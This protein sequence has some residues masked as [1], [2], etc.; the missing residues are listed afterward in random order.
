MN[1]I[2]EDEMPTLE[3]VAHEDAKEEVK[4]NVSEEDAT[5]EVKEGD[6]G[7]EEVVKGKDNNKVEDVI[8]IQDAVFTI[9][10][11]P[12]GTEIFDLQVSRMGGGEG[13]FSTLQVKGTLF[14][15]GDRSPQVT[16]TF[17]K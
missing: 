4:D 14:N 1:D 8:V 16:T 9:K 7:N 17:T 11:Q 13:R 5:T 6:E 10:I 2:D 3:K 12:P 15:S